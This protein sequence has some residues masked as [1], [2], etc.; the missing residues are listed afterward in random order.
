MYIKK[1]EYLQKNFKRDQLYSGVTTKSIKSLPIG[2]PCIIDLSVADKK[3]HADVLKSAIEGLMSYSNGDSTPVNVL[4]LFNIY[5]ESPDILTSSSKISKIY[6]TNDKPLIYDSYNS[7][8]L[9]SSD[10][11][12]VNNNIFEQLKDQLKNNRFVNYLFEDVKSTN[13]TNVMSNIDKI[14][15]SLIK[16][17]KNTVSFYH[18]PFNDSRIL[19]DTISISF[20]RMGDVIPIFNHRKSEGICME[21]TTANSDIKSGSIMR[22]NY[23]MTYRFLFS[24]YRENIFSI[25]GEPVIRPN[26]TDIENALSLLHKLLKKSTPVNTN[27]GSVK[28][29]ASKKPRNL[30]KQWQ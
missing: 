13:I 10:K 11:N 19:I 27:K 14:I 4:F 28:L 12:S 3:K 1:L 7:T 6:C 15:K 5:Q 26:D 20:Y 18:Y 29:T 21:I 16:N 22:G 24:K 25:D 30:K 8:F 9:K 23:Y 2:T 17:Y